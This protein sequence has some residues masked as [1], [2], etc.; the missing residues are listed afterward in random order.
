[1]E[2]GKLSQSSLPCLAMLYLPPL[3]LTDTLSHGGHS[4]VAL[5]AGLLELEVTEFSVPLPRVP[6]F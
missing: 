6:V 3:Q 2:L 5:P 4:W 1:M